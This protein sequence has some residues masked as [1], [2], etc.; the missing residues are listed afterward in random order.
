MRV[1]KG[2]VGK[3]AG[4]SESLT[5]LYHLH[6]N[7]CLQGLGRSCSALRSARMERETQRVKAVARKVPQA[8][9]HFSPQSYR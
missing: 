5:W 7:R 6:M 3:I 2:A 8:G 9:I 1:N 4:F